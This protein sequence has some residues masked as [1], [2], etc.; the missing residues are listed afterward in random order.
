VSFA[1]LD[2][3]FRPF[4]HTDQTLATPVTR[5][6][7]DIG[8]VAAER[9]TT[10]AMRLVLEWVVSVAKFV[11]FVVRVGS[12]TEIDQTVIGGDVVGVQAFVP[13]RARPD[14][15]LK[16]KLVNEAGVLTAWAAGFTTH[17][18]DYSAV[19]IRDWG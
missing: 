5:F 7:I 12:P 16:Y 6:E 18:D 11:L 19:T 17:I 1:T 3:A 8:A 10:L 15:R 2:R 9:V 14:E 13:W 4:A